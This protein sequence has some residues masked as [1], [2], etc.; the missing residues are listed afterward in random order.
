MGQETE[1]SSQRSTEYKVQFSARLTIFNEMYVKRNDPL[2]MTQEIAEKPPL[3]YLD[4][5]WGFVDTG[6][7]GNSKLSYQ[8]KIT[9][10]FKIGLIQWCV[11]VYATT[12]FVIYSGMSFS[13]FL[14][15]SVFRLHKKH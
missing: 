13:T 15:I 3:S 2:K 6:F 14:F 5:G 12:A 11:I 9:S 4:S 10:C 1:I 8:M 7:S